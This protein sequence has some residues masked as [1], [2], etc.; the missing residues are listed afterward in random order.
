MSEESVG[1]PWSAS[2]PFVDLVDLVA[3]LIY[4]FEPVQ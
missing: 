4:Y 2:D 3:A 1:W